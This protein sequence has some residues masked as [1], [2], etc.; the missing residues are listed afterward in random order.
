M[1]GIR[2][3]PCTKRR[4]V[5]TQRSA[6]R[7]VTGVRERMP[8]REAHEAPV[9]EVDRIRGGRAAVVAFASVAIGTSAVLISG[10]LLRLAE[11]AVGPSAPT[12]RGYEAVAPRANGRL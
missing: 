5:A 2:R 1:C 4:G 8:T 3:V 11:T 12:E 9:P 7:A 6:S 10:W